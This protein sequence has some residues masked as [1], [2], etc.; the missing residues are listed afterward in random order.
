MILDF[1]LGFNLQ[2]YSS[3]L[4]H[5]D[6][7]WNP[8]RL[9]QRNGRIGRKLQPAKQIICRYVEQREPDIMLEAPGG[10]RAPGGCATLALREESETDPAGTIPSGTMPSSA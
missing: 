3:D 10:G 8:S 9:E 2:N 4:V 5:F 7:P 1:E 6:L